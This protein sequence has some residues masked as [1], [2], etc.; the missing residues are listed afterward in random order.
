MTSL[1][2]SFPGTVPAI[3][4]ALYIPPR[5]RKPG[6]ASTGHGLVMV[7]CKGGVGQR[8]AITVSARS[9]C[10]SR[11]FPHRQR[12]SQRFLWCLTPPY[13]TFAVA[14]GATGA[15]YRQMLHAYEGHCTGKVT[16]PLIRLQ[17]AAYTKII[18]VALPEV[19]PVSQ[20]SDLQDDLHPGHSNAC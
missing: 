14:N 2:D 5:R 8:P 18:L 7:M 1:P 13:R 20:A 15:S 12:G 19:I 10:F 6:L 11:G 4:D 17:D 9:R 3:S 16:N